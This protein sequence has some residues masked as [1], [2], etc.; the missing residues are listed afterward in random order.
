MKKYI[1]IL[2][3][4]LIASLCGLAFTG[5]FLHNSACAAWMVVIQIITISITSFL[6]SRSGAKEHYEKPESLFDWRIK[7]LTNFG[8]LL[9][10]L[11]M[12]K[13]YDQ[14]ATHQW[15]SGSFLFW[16]G[17]LLFTVIAP[18]YFGSKLGKRFPNIVEKFYPY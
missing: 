1:G 9:L 11:S 16:T 12:C 14:L 2:Y 8:A 10:L 7:I 17:V 18:K 4:G 13:A 6:E 3:G 15:G 5:G